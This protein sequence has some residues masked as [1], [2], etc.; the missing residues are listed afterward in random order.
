[1][2]ISGDSLK[3]LVGRSGPDNQRVHGS[4]NVA[5]MFRPRSNQCAN[6][7]PLI[8]G[9][10]IALG[11]VTAGAA[12]ND[13]FNR[14]EWLIV[15]AVEVIG[16]RNPAAMFAPENLFTAV[17]AFLGVRKTNK[18]IEAN[19]HFA[20]VPHGVHPKPIVKRL[21]G[22]QPHA[23]RVTPA[24]FARA[25]LEVPASDYFDGS[26]IAL[27]LIGTATSIVESGK[28]HHGPFTVSFV[29]AN[30]SRSGHLQLPFY[31][32]IPNRRKVTQPMA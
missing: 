14:I 11:S 28:F 18:L 25:V 30:A 21:E 31:R 12:N 23:A 29:F 6:L 2:R 1:M 9:K 17:M 26:A 15:F 24:A 27:T 10:G 32:P 22:Q 13:C 5:I 19:Q 16:R 8:I 3:S 20:T 7:H 4:V